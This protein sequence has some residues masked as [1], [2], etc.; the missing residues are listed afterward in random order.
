M[1]RIIQNST[2]LS[3]SFTEMR[4]FEFHIIDA[5]GNYDI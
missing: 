3:V 4:V 1:R 5:E 2:V